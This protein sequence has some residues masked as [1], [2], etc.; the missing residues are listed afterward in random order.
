MKYIKISIMT[1]YFV[2]ILI[3]FFVSCQ[4]QESSLLTIPVTPKELIDIPLSAITDKLEKIELETT[5]EC[6]ISRVDQVFCNDKYIITV[7]PKNIFLFDKKGK[8]ISPIGR[9]GNG[10]G[11]FPHIYKTG[12]DW[13]KN[14]LY[15]V[16]PGKIICFNLDGMVT[17]EKKVDFSGIV[18]YI[19]N[20]DNSICIIQETTG[21]EHHSSLLLFDKTLSSLTDSVPIR[22][23]SLPRM[24]TTMSFYEDFV[25]V[26]DKQVFLYY[27]ELNPEKC[28]RDTLY[29][30]KENRVEPYLRLSFE[31]VYKADGY[32]NTYLM[33]IYK[34]SRFVFATYTTEDDQRT[35][36][37]F[38]YDMKSKQGGCVAGYTDD[39][40]T[41]EKVIIHPLHINGEKFWFMKT[42]WDGEG[43]EPNP[44]LFIGTLK[45]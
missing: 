3:L 1:K 4:E 40:V 9:I 5:E 11:E 10:P 13:K 42:V 2:F 23:V 22:T 31:D 44:T 18:K 17:K 37:Q 12:M 19:A 29:I 35:V 32:K 26:E 25:T 34:S 15:V 20:I 39:F 27:P 8:F 24:M 21:K 45:K 41:S 43:D 16:C 33:N 30:V 38:C 7:G 36:K 6:L 14:E 28:M